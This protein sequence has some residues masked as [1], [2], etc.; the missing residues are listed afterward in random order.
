MTVIRE[1]GRSNPRHA[2]LSAA[3]FP[4]CVV[5]PRQYREPGAADRQGRDCA[6]R[7]IAERS[8][9]RVGGR[10]RSLRHSK[11]ARRLKRLPRG[12]PAVLWMSPLQRLGAS[13]SRRSRETFASIATRL[14][15]RGARLRAGQQRAQCRLGRGSTVSAVLGVAR[16]TALRA[17]AR[18]QSAAQ[19]AAWRRR[20][21][22]RAARAR[23]DR[24]V[25]AAPCLGTAGPASRPPTS[26]RVTRGRP[27]MLGRQH[28]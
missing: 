6:W 22:A 17:R 14:E 24:A 11:L 9:A 15:H 27:T 3:P 16:G 10:P 23:S 19:Q 26:A 2:P 1:R 25:P 28:I 21:R 7:D 12:C 20:E 4:T 8:S 18:P 5:A 13:R